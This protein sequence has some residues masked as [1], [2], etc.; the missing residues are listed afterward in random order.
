MKPALSGK[1][2]IKTWRLGAGPELRWGSAR[3]M[4]WGNVMNFST[5]R[6]CA[7]GA[8]VMQLFGLPAGA[9]VLEPYQAMASIPDSATCPS[10]QCILNFPAVPR[11]KRLVITSVSAQLGPASNQLV[12]EGNGVAY[13]VPKSHPDLGY[14]AVPVTVYLSAGSAP[15]ARIFA[16]DTTQHTS[17]IVTLVGHLVPQ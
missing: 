15:T 12:L 8:L 10:A 14:L 16:P 3:G 4:I 5:L 17:L 11:G 9:Q 6:M 7:V 1:C 2:R 13:F